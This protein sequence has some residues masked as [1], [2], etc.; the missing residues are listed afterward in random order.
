MFL[1]IATEGLSALRIYMRKM[2]K[3]G[4]KRKVITVSMHGAQALLGYMVMIA[5]MTFSIEM[6]L[7]VIFGIGIGYSLFFDDT[8]SSHVSTNPCCAFI[9]EEESKEN[10]ENT[11]GVETATD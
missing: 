3:A 6:L 11:P 5:T 1:A 9:D 4:M 7:S 10:L 8:S 2:L